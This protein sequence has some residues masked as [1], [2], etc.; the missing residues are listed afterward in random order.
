MRYVEHSFHFVSN[1]RDSI[2]LLGISPSNVE[3][4]YGWIEKG[5]VID[6]PWNMK[7]H[8]VTRFWEKP[9][10]SKAEVLFLNGCLWNTFVL[11]GHISTF[12]SQFKNVIPDIYD[13][14]YHT[15]SLYNPLERKSILKEIYP[16][17]PMI[18]FS[19]VI[20]ESCTDQLCVMEVSDTNWSDWGNEH[21][22]LSDIERHNLK[23]HEYEAPS[24]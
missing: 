8:K 22:I 1:Y 24:T 10:Q 2:M 6:N 12:L 7:I 17:F 11:V 18:N 13:Q 5:K 21:R 23:L 4:E 3:A 9:D 19:K 14:L 15:I 20:L 16:S